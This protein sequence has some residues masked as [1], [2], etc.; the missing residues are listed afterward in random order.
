MVYE[1]SHLSILWKFM[2]SVP[3]GSS[4]HDYVKVIT[5]PLAS[6]SESLW[7]TLDWWIKCHYNDTKIVIVSIYQSI[8]C[9]LPSLPGSEWRADRGPDL[10]LSVGPCCDQL[11]HR[12]TAPAAQSKGGPSY[13]SLALFVSLSE[14]SRT[15]T[16]MRLLIIWPFTLM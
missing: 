2:M 6:N 3:I 16:D 11:R 15:S 13:Y 10:G 5:N 7:Q 8:A 4:G 12:R 1:S 9:N 14:S